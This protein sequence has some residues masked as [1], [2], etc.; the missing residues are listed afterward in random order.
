MAVVIAI[1]FGFVTPMSPVQILWVNLIT[2]VTLDLALAFEASRPG[3]MARPPRSAAAPLLSPFLL[4]R[5]AFVSILFTAGA[6]GVFLHAL[7]SGRDLETART[8]VV[9]AIVVFETV[10]L[11]DV[12]ARHLSTVDPRRI[13]GA[14][15]VIVSVTIVILA[16]IAFTFAPFMQTL[17]DSRPLA[18]ADLVV[19]LLAGVFFLVVLEIEATVTRRLRG[20][21]MDR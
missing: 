13:L 15:P 20:T 19:L 11:L 5:V 17:F 4:W 18:P 12:R 8:L 2:T 21:G 3:I 7:E 10:Y 1:L 16:Q 9:N 14:R 6:L